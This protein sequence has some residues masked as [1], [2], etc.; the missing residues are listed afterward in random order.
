MFP[1]V[2]GRRPDVRRPWCVAPPPGL[3]LVLGVATEGAV[4]VRV[5]AGEDDRAG[6]DVADGHLVRVRVKVRV[7]VRVRVSDRVRVRVR[8]RL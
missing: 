2:G 1:R 4:Q 5:A 6:E 7:R 8:V 3:H